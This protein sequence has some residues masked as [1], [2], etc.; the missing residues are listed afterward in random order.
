MTKIIKS[1]LN[2]SDLQ[3]GAIK[4]NYKVLDVSRRRNAHTQKRGNENDYYFKPEPIIQ[5]YLLNVTL[6]ILHATLPSVI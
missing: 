6:I 1:G 2:N 5:H 4:I 3:S